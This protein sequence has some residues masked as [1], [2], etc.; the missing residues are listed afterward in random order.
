MDIFS[1]HEP[2]LMGLELVR[3][4]DNLAKKL[5]SVFDDDDL[6]E[7]TEF[8]E[9]YVDIRG[10]DVREEVNIVL[11]SSYSV[12]GPN[13]KTKVRKF[14]GKVEIVPESDELIGSQIEKVGQDFSED[15]IVSD[16]NIKMVLQLPINN[17]KQDIK[18]TIHDNNDNNSVTISY[19]DH[20]GRKCAYTSDIP[21]NVDFEIAKATF[22]N[23]IL[24]IRINRK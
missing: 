16:K 9:F 2:D 21:Y 23:G 11:D 8:S 19:L 20:E 5:Y 1:D 10:E 14:K 7:W 12:V 17:R 15:V 24:E 3:E 18:V 6:N 4:F 22:K 13:K